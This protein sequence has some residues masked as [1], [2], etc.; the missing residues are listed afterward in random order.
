[1][2]SLNKISEKVRDRSRGRNDCAMEQIK[3][4]LE[5]G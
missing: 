3:G 1:M 2:F 4:R 5:V